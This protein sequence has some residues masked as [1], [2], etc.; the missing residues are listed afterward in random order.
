MEEIFLAALDSS[1]DELLFL[2]VKNQTRPNKAALKS[3]I[4][5]SSKKQAASLCSALARF[6]NVQVLAFQNLGNSQFEHVDCFKTPSP[7]HKRRK[8][9]CSSPAAGAK[10]RGQDSGNSGRRVFVMASLKACAM[11]AQ[12]GLSHPLKAFQPCDLFPTVQTLHDQLVFFE[13]D[14]ELQD[15]IATLC[16]NWWKDNL[17]GRE[18]LIAQSL[19]FLLSKSL[20]VGRKVNVHRVYG[21]REAFV[22]FDFVDETIEDLKHL[23]MRCMLTPAYLRSPDGWRFIS[24]L[25]NINVQLTKELIVMVRSQIPF[26]RK[27]ILEAYGD[28]I[29]R[30]WR[31]ASGPCLQEIEDS[32]VQGLIEGAVYASSKTLASSIRKV[33]AA[34]TCQRAQDGVETLLFTLQEPILFRSLQVA[35]SNVR[36]NALLLLIDMFPLENPNASKE[37]N[38]LLL[39]KQLF[40]MEKLL[41]DSCPDVRVTAVEGVC[42][43]LR[44]FWEVVP[45]GLTVKLLSKIVDEVAHD[46]SS[47]SVRCAVLQGVT[48]LLENPASHDLLKVILPRLAPLLSDC[49]LSVRIEMADMLLALKGIRAISFLKVTSLELLLSALE[50]DKPAV[51]RRL[52]KLLI[53]SYFPSKVPVLEACNRC[54]ALIKRSPK[55]GVRFCEWAS[56]EGVTQSSLLELVRVLVDLLTSPDGTSPHGLEA[57]AQESI[58]A[59]LNQ[60]C[61]TLANQKELKMLLGEI[62]TSKKLRALLSGAA[63][64]SSRTSIVQMVSI[65]NPTDVPELFEYCSQIITNFSKATLSSINCNEARSVHSLMLAWGGFD[66]LVKT[67]VELLA[68][69][70]EGNEGLGTTFV[71]AKSGKKKKSDSKSPWTKSMKKKVTLGKPKKGVEVPRPLDNLQSALGAAWH[72]ENLVEV[73]ETRQ[74]LL[75]HESLPTLVSGLR[76]AVHFVLHSSMEIPVSDFLKGSPI[77]AYATLAVHKML[78]ENAG[79]K[80]GNAKERQMEQNNS[81]LQVS[82]ELIEWTE[83]LRNIPQP[84]TPMFQMKKRAKRSRNCQAQRREAL[85]DISN[86]TPCGASTKNSSEAEVFVSRVNL[87]NTSLESLLY[88]VS[89]KLVKDGA[90]LGACLE[91]PMK[92]MEW[93][94]SWLRKWEVVEASSKVLGFKAKDILPY[95]KTCV[96]HC[97]K[98]LY[99]T[100]RN[101]TEEALKFADLANSLLK[102]LVFSESIFG[103]KGSMSLLAALNPW[104]PDLLI[105]ISS[106]TVALISSEEKADASCLCFNDLV[107][108]GQKSLK[109]WV[110]SLVASASE[111]SNQEE[112]E[113]G[114]PMAEDE[115]PGQEDRQEP[116]E[117]LQPASKVDQKLAFS[118]EIL[119]RIGKLLQR[120][121]RLVL[122]GISSLF[123]WHA[124]ASLNTEDYSAA[125]GA[126]RI[127]CQRFLGC[128]LP[129]KGGPK[130]FISEPFVAAFK[131]MDKQPLWMLTMSAAGHNSEGDT[132]APGMLS[133]FDTSAPGMKQEQCWQRDLNQK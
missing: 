82:K 53:P 67:L 32:C 91:Y 10:G 68:Q 28:I 112:N 3:A 124:A 7:K 31:T 85:T 94:M 26:G 125:V 13:D 61:H 43:V 55:A 49:N 89:L 93:I 65:I 64:S 109:P 17:P 9:A 41:T 115:H 127:V 54:V 38:D 48:Y 117:Y 44:L 5:R 69:V 30:A 42:R 21:M 50:S 130:T 39:E 74:E 57:E 118:R 126:L 66:D 4:H 84:T 100:L 52:T 47:S 20:E 101:N 108:L 90:L 120:G 37:E 110:A 6:A 122:E 95:I 107:C 34:F 92:W 22:L 79:Q 36:R 71:S 46:Y 75:A 23:L 121:D 128:R 62:L 25:F 29:F 51:A 40:F 33:L 35:N 45:S 27:S 58:F 12:F 132:S 99:L 19:P 11:I 106:L 63:T 14:L 105:S 73:D 2:I 114:S 77:R 70:S 116:E 86:N 83:S 111:T 78:K 104:F 72:L 123:L 76:N 24:F 113:P 97:G 15:I 102:F 131:E 18:S 16:E 96:S 119:G 81:I 60:L 87:L 98:M 56:A 88:F 133:P 8:R 1:P 129:K 103:S 59:V 80:T